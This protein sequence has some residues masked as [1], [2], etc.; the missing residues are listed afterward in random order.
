MS[1]NETIVAN[2][3]KASNLTT[4]VAAVQAAGLV[5]TLQG[6]GPFTVF[7][8]DNAAFEKIPEATRTSLMQPAMKADLTKILTYHVVAGKWDA[9]SLVA[10]IKKD[11][12]KSTIKT[13]SGGELV[14]WVKDGKVGI[15]DEKGGTAWVTIADVNQSNG[16]IHV[17]D[18]VLMPK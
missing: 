7:A 18:T 1:P 5:D 4:L 9:A 11:G 13:V 15:N 10:Q 17:I 14:A 3:S 12:G 8:P 2:A 6:A 16:V